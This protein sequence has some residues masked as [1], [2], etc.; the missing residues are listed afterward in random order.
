MDG[1]IPHI[2]KKILLGDHPPRGVRGGGDWDLH[3]PALR[4]GKQILH[5]ML[6]QIIPND[7]LMWCGCRAELSLTGF[8]THDSC[9]S[10]NKYANIVGRHSDW[11]HSLRFQAFFWPRTRLWSWRSAGQSWTSQSARRLSSL[12]QHRYRVLKSFVFFTI[13]EKSGKPQ[14]YRTR[15]PRSN[16]RSLKWII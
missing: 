10:H 5:A 16:R 1:G 6:L 13:S 3:W 12:C 11:Q 9:N 15:A 14:W 2:K 8:V 4:T 7:Y